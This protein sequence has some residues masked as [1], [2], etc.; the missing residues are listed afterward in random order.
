MNPTS[1][2]FTVWGYDILIRSHHIAA[3]KDHMTSFKHNSEVI[4]HDISLC[5]SRQSQ[6]LHKPEVPVKHAL[7]D[8]L[9]PAVLVATALS[10]NTVKQ[11]M[12]AWIHLG[13][14]GRLIKEKPNNRSQNCFPQG[15]CSSK[16]T[17][18]NPPQWTLPDVFLRKSPNT[19]G[20][21][22]FSFYSNVQGPNCNTKPIPPK[23]SQL[24]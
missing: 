9:R 19:E 12:V 4:I 8:K 18:R 22:G 23:S 7:F 3:R 1:V 5:S 14:F 24:Q 16:N 10:Y 15:I 11:E 2:D 17:S 6:R 21:Q 13:K 20:A